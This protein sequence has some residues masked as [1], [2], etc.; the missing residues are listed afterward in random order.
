MEFDLKFVI[1]IYTILI[2]LLYLH[3]N[4]L[5]NLNVEKKN[6]KVIYLSFLLIILAIISFYVKILY[7]CF[8]S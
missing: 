2:V 7:E 3:N 8:F 5:F 4:N 1:I 6:K